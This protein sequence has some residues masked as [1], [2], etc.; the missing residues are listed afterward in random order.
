[1]SSFSNKIIA[2]FL[3]ALWCSPS[4]LA[5]DHEVVSP[6]GNYKISLHINNGIQ[7]EIYAGQTQLIAPS[8]I[9]MTLQDGTIIGNGTILNIENSSVNQQLPVLFGK[10]SV[11][12]E[13][14]N[15]SIVH[16]NEKYDLVVRAYNEGIAYRFITAFTSNIIVK[17]EDA[18]FH[19]A[20]SPKVYFPEAT[21]LDHWEKKYD[22]YTS[23]NDLANGRLAV[24]PIL[25]SY[26]NTTY[27][28]AITEADNNDYPGLYIQ[29]SGTDLMKGM[30]AQYPDSVSDPTN[31]YSNHFPVT[32]FNYLANTTGTRSFP[33]RVFV[34]SSDDKSLLN[35][36][37][38]YMLAQPLK[39]TDVSWIVP[40]KS[41]WEWWHKAMLEGVDFPV[42]N[43]NLG[44][45][46]YKYYV[47]FA[48]QNHFEY[49]TLDAGWN[50]SY[51]S[52]LCTYAKSKNVKIIVWTWASCA[53]ESPNWIAKMKRYGVS[54]VK[55]DFFNRNDQIAMGWGQR[56]AQELANN[57]MIGVF[58]GCPVPTGLNR[59]YPNMLNFESVL[60]EEEDFWRRGSSPDYHV[61]FPF[62]RSLVG[63]E[64]YTPGSMRNKTERQFYPVDLPNTVPFSQGTRAHEL[65]MFVIFDQWL[66]YMS[67]APT[68]YAKYPDILDYLSKV[69]TVW[70][71]T[72]PLDAKLGEYI[73]IAKQK[74]TEWF[75]GGMCSWAAKDIEVD[76]SFLKPD[77]KYMATVLRDDYNSSDYPTKYV[78]EQVEVTSL[79]KLTYSMAKGG[80]F[81]IRLTES[82]STGM[83]S[84]KDQSTISVLVDRASH[85]I[86]VS[87]QEPIDSVELYST[88][89]ILVYSQNNLADKATSR[90][91]DLSRLNSG[92]FIVK[93]K[94]TDNTNFSK[95]IL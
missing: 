72:V 49:M 63:P 31:I 9:G 29:K 25:F 50:E 53:L 20:G 76:F 86:N 26:P 52:S 87:S 11:L 40:G 78:N 39:L 64:D 65:S 38:V 59:A 75:V 95:I 24:T 70:D 66:G 33:W 89:G 32:R 18:S 12:Q 80:G 2:C 82:G 28:V 48:S 35:N 69:P 84:N 19:F 46:L 22:T 47:D 34:L 43:D 37:L 4:L 42:G 14:Y 56:L 93:I 41:S 61:Q 85:W 5:V 27:K 94:T 67:D 83:V 79:S 88:S 23:V 10:N 55:I 45:T 21:T 90:Q 62:I 91:F 7:Y 3:T 60:G 73:L 1:M 15:Q 8:T 77:T 92:T 71:K 17:T 58:H 6:N 36:E 51:I 54:G 81:A 57:H 74:G 30:W 68:E 13:N 44:L 16:F